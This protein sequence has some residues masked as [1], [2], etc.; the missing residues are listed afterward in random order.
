MAT[1]A[2]PFGLCADLVRTTNQEPLDSLIQEIIGNR[3]HGVQMDVIKYLLA[4]TTID[5][6][7]VLLLG[8]TQYRTEESIKKEHTIFNFT[9]K[10]INNVARL[11][12]RGK[13]A[14]L[15]PFKIGG[16]YDVWFRLTNTDTFTAEANEWGLKQQINLSNLIN[17]VNTNNSRDAEFLK[18]RYG[19]IIHSPSIAAEGLN[20]FKIESIRDM[21]LYNFIKENNFKYFQVFTGY[22][23]LVNVELESAIEKLAKYYEMN[24]DVEIYHSKENEVPKRI[25]CNGVGFGLRT[26]DWVG[27]FELDWR[28]GP[29]HS[30][31]KYFESQLRWTDPVS[32][33][34][35]FGVISSNG[36]T[37]SRKF[38]R[39]TK[40]LNLTD[41]EKANWKPDIRITIPVTKEEFKNSE[42]KQIWLMIEGDL[43][44]DKT[45][46]VGL[47]NQIRN[48][49]P[50]Q[51]RLRYIVSVLSESIK[52]NMKAGLSVEGV[53]RKSTIT[54]GYAIHEMVYETLKLA[55]KY[56]DH[57][58]NNFEDKNKYISPELLA[59]VP[60]LIEMDKI[61]SARSN[62]RKREGIKFESSVKSFIQDNV[63]TINDGFD[64]LEIEWEDKDDEISV[65][66]NL[67]ENQ[68]IDLLGSVVIGG[69]QFRIACQMKDKTSALPDKEI[70]KFT[71]TILALKQQYPNDTYFSYLVVAN[72]KCING[73]IVEKLQPHDIRIVIEN[74]NQMIGTRLAE[75]IGRDIE[76]IFPN[77]E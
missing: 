74:Q 54:Q 50:A 21:E 41:E 35:H 5:G 70:Q 24:K 66:H 4:Q 36:S 27:S 40:S 63:E 22:F 15:L 56:L 29:E 18:S 67:G 2:D 17:D 46:L 53:K 47:D 12:T 38:N 51:S 42:Y 23:P 33:T 39:R 60:K 19:I 61:H 3:K 45:G 48:M 59:L 75:S 57:L 16:Q 14:K 31:K 69:R 73:S 64:E 10:D 52:D 58:G 6:K 55:K 76:K 72:S 71:N 20:T 44:S 65:A 30:S 9:P 1:S 26:E 8:S 68:G 13:G 77:S 11:G 7:S 49:G 28:L 32:K 43:I 62:Q 25:S 37:E 34:Y